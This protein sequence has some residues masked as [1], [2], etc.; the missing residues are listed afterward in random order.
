[1]ERM[2]GLDASFLYVETPTAHMHVSAVMVL[3]PS[4]IPDG[5]Y[6]FDWVL[7]QVERRLVPQKEF[8]RI[9]VRVPFNLNHPVWIEDPH[10]EL[11]RHVKRIGVA[12]PGGPEELAEL[13]DEILGTPLERTKPLW[14]IWVVEGLER[15]HVGLVAKMHHA[16]I[17][18][19]TGT[20][21]MVHLFDLEAAAEPPPRPGLPEPEEVPS[22]LELV[23]HGI[24]SR[25]RR[26]LRAVRTLR[27]TGEAAVNVARRRLTGAGGM[28]APFRAPRTSLNGAITPRRSTAFVD[29]SLDDVK[30]VKDALGVTVNDVVLAVCGGTLARYLEEN[31]ENPEKA[32]TAI[33]P[34]S[35]HG[36]SDG[37]SSGDSSGDRSGDSSGDTAGETGG[38]G[39]NKIS[40]L[41]ASL[42][43]DVADPIERIRQVSEVSRAAKDEHRAVGA[44]FLQ[45]WGE[46]T[47]PNIGLAMRLYSR[48]KLAE[49]HTP[50]HNLVISNVPGPPF[51]L[52][53]GGAELVRLHPLGPIF[54]GTA[55]NI[56]V[57]SYLDQIGFGLI[58]CPANVPDIRRL[59]GHIPDA[60]HE[61]LEATGV[62]A[63]ASRRAER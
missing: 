62:A 40:A 25:V 63:T 45:G 32:L 9:P 23:L 30:A 35:V 21:M 59:A 6:S 17:D 53:F 33:C 10:F 39:T 13:A 22:D 57:L 31:G 34:V 43:T 29:V 56:T 46:F 11:R 42:A 49:R 14:E 16:T 61:L 38:D 51:P 18:G 12:A 41:F 60:L 24:R 20:N 19:V 58:A 28:P 15:G 47:G 5:E 2:S 55:L 4:T 8:R 1:M 44:G 26:P 54:D 37:D 48:T 36:D 3:D 50:F 7:D 27:D 52:Y